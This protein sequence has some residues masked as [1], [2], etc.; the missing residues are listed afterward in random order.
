MK[1]MEKGSFFWGGLF[2]FDYMSDLCFGSRPGALTGLLCFAESISGSDGHPKSGAPPARGGR[3]PAAQVGCPTHEGWCESN[4]RKKDLGG[5]E[6]LQRFKKRF[7][8]FHCLP[9]TRHCFSSFSTYTT[10]ANQL[11]L[12]SEQPVTIATAFNSPRHPNNLQ[13]S[14]QPST[15]LY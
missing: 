8:P 10:A 12:S 3:A 1:I 13:Q 7:I 4:R 9:F 11:P 6:E 5:K 2:Y 14:K 15:S